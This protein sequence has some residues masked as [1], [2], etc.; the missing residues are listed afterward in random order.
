MKILSI[1]AQKPHSTGSGIYLTEMV[2]NWHLLGHKQAVVA[3]VYEGEDVGFPEE[4]R[5]YPVQYKSDKLPFAITGMSDEMPYESVRYIDLSEEMQRQYRETFQRVIAKAVKELEPDVIIC[6]HIYLLTAMVREWYPDKKVFGLSHGSDVRQICKNPLKRDYI[7][8]QIRKLNGITALHKAHQKEIQQIFGCD[9]EKVKIIGVGYNQNIFYKAQK[10][11][12][13]NYQLA[14]AGKVTEKKGIFSLIRALG[15]LPYASG[16]LAVKIAGGYGTE[17][18]YEEIKRLTAE[19]KYYIE[20]LGR[21]G[22]RELAEVFRQSDVFV[23]PS[24]FEGLP[25]VNIEAM[26]C[27]CKVVCSDISGIKEWYDENVPGHRMELVPLPGMK[28]TDEPLADELP[29]FEQRLANAIQKK[30]E[31]TE[32][33]YPDLEQISWK[34][35]SQKILKEFCGEGETTCL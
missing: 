35:I 27:G 9:K 24:F 2:N 22:Q 14:F 4:V 17:E 23:L 31:Q 10:K 16:Q 28:N 34:G 18:E 15:Q 26:A 7:K 21:L 30:L 3:G 20:L 29:G 1:T 11:Q 25:L 32:E 33:E 6:H 12:K 8:E 13:P 5:F 19:S